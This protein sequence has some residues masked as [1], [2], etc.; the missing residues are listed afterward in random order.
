MM[1]TYIKPNA[2]VIDLKTEGNVV[3]GSLDTGTE[4]VGSEPGY[5]NKYH[6]WNAINWSDGSEG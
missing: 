3:T 5:S 2:Q 1:K 6:G 4:V